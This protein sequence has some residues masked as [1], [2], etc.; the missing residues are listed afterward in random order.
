MGW[1]PEER[2][3]DQDTLEEKRAR[4]IERERRRQEKEE[5]YQKAKDNLPGIDRSGEK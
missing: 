1:L 4:A 2:E 3:A 5:A